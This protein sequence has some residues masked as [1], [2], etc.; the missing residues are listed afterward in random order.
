MS[1]NPAGTPRPE[2][3]YVV[4][5]ALVNMTS[6]N[7]TNSTNT[8]RVWAIP[9][10]CSRGRKPKSLLALPKCTCCLHRQ[11]LRDVH[12]SPRRH[13]GIVCLSRCPFAGVV[14]RQHDR[15]APWLDRAAPSGAPRWL[16]CPV[17]RHRTGEDSSATLPTSSLPPVP[18]TTS[19][20][21]PRYHPQHHVFTSPCAADVGG[22]D[23]V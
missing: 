4:E 21:A 6:V 19:V 9:P 8:T 2:V 12:T 13:P 5:G 20:P 10:A 22:D 3:P 23:A 16:A 1:N 18:T 11:L 17:E 7:M 14:S 15:D